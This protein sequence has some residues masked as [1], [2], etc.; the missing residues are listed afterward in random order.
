MQ[1]VVVLG[2]APATIVPHQRMEAVPIMSTRS[3]SLPLTSLHQAGQS[4]GGAEG[5]GAY[6]ASQLL[7]RTVGD[8]GGR[9]RYCGKRIRRVIILLLVCWRNY[10][11]VLSSETFL[12]AGAGQ[13]STARNNATFTISYKFNTFANTFNITF[14]YL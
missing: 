2:I 6:D 5:V 12:G 13:Q 3:W 11:N 8:C 9:G 1:P 10:R 4:D 14:I 7:P